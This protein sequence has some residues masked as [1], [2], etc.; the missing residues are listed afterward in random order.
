MQVPDPKIAIVE[1]LVPLDEQMPDES[2]TDEKVTANPE[3][4]VA[5]TVNGASP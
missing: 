3:D 2:A 4:A 1:P 5:D